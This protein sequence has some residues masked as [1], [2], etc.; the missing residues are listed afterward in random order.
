MMTTLNIVVHGLPFLLDHL[1][2]V[3]ITED[4][5]HHLVHLVLPTEQ[6]H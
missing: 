4:V 5:D 1:T 3:E 2:V 6:E